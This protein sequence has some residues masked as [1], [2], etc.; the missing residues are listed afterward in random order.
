MSFRCE[1]PTLGPAMDL[2]AQFQARV[3]VIETERFRLRAPVLSDFPAFVEIDCSERGRFIGGPESQEDAWFTFIGIA[4]GWYFHRHGGW[5]ITERPGD[6]PL[7]FIV[8]GLE[9]GDQEVELGYLLCEAAEGRG[10]ATETT[11]AVRDWAE[12]ALN[13]T[14]LVSYIDP[15]NTASAAVAGRLGA[16]RDATAEAAFADDPIHVYR[17][18]KPEARP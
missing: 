11:R 9:P 18:P 16:T 10:V 6:D 2:A 3:P 17:H 7:G 5:T 1:Q 15:E 13:L 4:S 14:G 12:S 8:L